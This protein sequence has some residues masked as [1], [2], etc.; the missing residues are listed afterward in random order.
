MTKKE[1]LRKKYEAVLL[2]WMGSGFEVQRFDTLEEAVEDA[3][4]ILTEE[5][6]YRHLYSSILISKVKQV[7]ENVFDAEEVLIV[8]NQ[9]ETWKIV[10]IK[11]EEFEEKSLF[12]YSLEMY[13]DE[14]ERQKDPEG[15]KKKEEERFKK[16][17]AKP[18]AEAQ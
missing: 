16:M 15:Y 2:D 7:S 4:R 1:Y 10:E 18:K 3:K 6:P 13:K 5:S 14:I 11:P 9:P 17:L 12:R 8:E